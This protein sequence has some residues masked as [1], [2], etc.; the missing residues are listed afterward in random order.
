MQDIIDRAKTGDVPSNWQIY[1][2][3]TSSIGLIVT[4]VFTAPFIYCGLSSGR[5]NEGELLLFGIPTIIGFFIAL[6]CIGVIRN[7]KKS[8][9]VIMPSG[10]VMSNGQGKTWSLDF[11]IVQ[12]LCIASQIDISGD[13]DTVSTTHVHWLDVYTK[14]GRYY[15]WYIQPAFGDDEIMCKRIIAAFEYYK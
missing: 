10:V 5:L 4:A 9:L 6:Y 8:Y 13:D 11:G 14:D 3:H 1:R 15:P 7:T 12:N 2:G